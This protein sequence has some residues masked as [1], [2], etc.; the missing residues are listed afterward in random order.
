[1]KACRKELNM[2]N[3]TGKAGRVQKQD[4]ESEGE[5]NYKGSFRK[6][7]EGQ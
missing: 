7:K 5:Q 3:K 1:M 2:G 6:K 4:V